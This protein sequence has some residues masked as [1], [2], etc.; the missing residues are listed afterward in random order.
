[1]V[2]LASRIAAAGVCFVTLT[3][4]SGPAQPTLATATRSLV[5]N[6]EE[7]LASEPVQSAGLFQITEKAEK[8]SD[9]ACVH[10][11]K[12]RFFRAQRNFVRPGHLSPQPDWYEADSSC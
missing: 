6:G 2:K 12:Q 3:G 8:D 5:S 9:T 7:L 10:G 1:M 4:C 11:S